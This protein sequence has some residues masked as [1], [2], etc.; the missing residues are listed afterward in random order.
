MTDTSAFTAD[1]PPKLPLVAILRG[2]QPE[3]AVAIARVL[4]DAGF[5]AIEVPL[6]RPGALDAIAAV[7]P[8]APADAWVGAG[9]VLE[10]S[11]VDA[12]ADTGA[13]L[14]VSPHFD[15][16]VVRRAR[17]RGLRSVPGIFTASEAFAAWRAGADA[18]KIFP[19]EAMTHD[20]LKGLTTVLPA[21]LP[22][23]PVG[24]IVPGNV[25]AWRRAGATGF[26]LGGGLFKPEFGVDEIAAKARAFVDAW[27]AGA[28]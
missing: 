19:A 4:F 27:E 11:Q 12:V 18:L 8:L 13:G 7:V 10:P 6:N 17:E 14:I 26:G 5:R 2:L 3:R 15:P 22:L 23:W 1:W 9:T 25:A 21:G 28:A 20:G 16:A 24:S